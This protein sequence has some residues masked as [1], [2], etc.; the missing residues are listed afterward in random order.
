M[1]PRKY[2][3]VDLLP[4]HASTLALQLYMDLRRARINVAA[5]RPSVPTG[6]EG[7]VGNRLDILGMLA[8]ELR[9]ETKSTPCNIVPQTILAWP[10]VRNEVENLFTTP[11]GILATEH[12]K[13]YKVFLLL[14]D[15]PKHK[16]QR[17]ES[18]ALAKEGLSK[19]FRYFS[20]ELALRN[21]VVSQ[22]KLY[23]AP[24]AVFENGV[25]YENP[26]EYDQWVKMIISRAT[27]NSM[28]HRYKEFV[29]SGISEIYHNNTDKIQLTVT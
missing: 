10:S 29:R 18:R 27:F 28:S 21:F 7:S 11:F 14:S 19:K 24:G 25:G 13:T 26:R 8:N 5:P 3:L 12:A 15:T 16:P 17:D 9:M 4:E 6:I 1:A 23:L 2:A 20:D 22:E